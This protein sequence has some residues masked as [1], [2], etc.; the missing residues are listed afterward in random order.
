MPAGREVVVIE[1]GTGAGLMVYGTACEVDPPKAAGSVGV[2][3]A[4]R[5]WV[6]AVSEVVEVVAVLAVT[7]AAGPR[8]AP[9]AWNWTLPT[10]AVG[11]TL[12]VRLTVVPAGWG[13][14]G[15]E[16]EELFREVGG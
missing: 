8:L 3:T 16:G 9:S 13:L 10:A 14:A 12:A 7:L 11:V 1:K 6:P 2:K 4:V 15:V 5:L